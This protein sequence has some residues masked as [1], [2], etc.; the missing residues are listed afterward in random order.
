MKELIEIVI[1]RIELVCLALNSQISAR[2][3]EGG[4]FGLILVLIVHGRAPLIFRAKSQEPRESHVING[5]FVSLSRPS[6]GIVMGIVVVGAMELSKNF[7]VPIIPKS[8]DIIETNFLAFVSDGV[9]H[10]VV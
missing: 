2:K 10:G 1:V 9:A 7:F 4:L 6:D 8:H 5:A 3:H